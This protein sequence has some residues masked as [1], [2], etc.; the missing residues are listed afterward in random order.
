MAMPN[1]R[2]FCG[3]NYQDWLEVNLTD[4]CNGRCSWCIERD[5]WHPQYHATWNVIADAAIKSGKANIILLG[6]EPTLHPDLS[7][8]VARIHEAGLRCW[9]TT[10]GSSLSAS[11]VRTNLAGIHGV[12]ISVH[13]YNLSRNRDITGISLNFYTLKS[14]VAAIKQLGASVRLNCTCMAD[15]IDSEERIWTYVQFAKAMECNHV[16]FAE[17]KMEGERFV[18]LAEVLNHKYGLNDEPFHDG[19]NTDVEIDRVNV[20]FRQ[21]CGLQTTK[22][23]CPENPI[24]YGKTVLYYDGQM[25]S[26]WQR[27]KRSSDMNQNE[28]KRIMA[29][30]ASGKMSA[31]EGQRKIEKLIR[32]AEDQLAGIG[33]GCQY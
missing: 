23:A 29:D 16:R 14:A 18:D 17:L 15:E 7:K 4:V 2:N 21:M 12:N 30:V 11:W 9:L 26:G 32:K 5:G 6:G 13:H 19:C 28:I 1:P 3:G 27:N 20:N 10:N 31:E 25:Y 22:R 8:I 24:Q 33:N